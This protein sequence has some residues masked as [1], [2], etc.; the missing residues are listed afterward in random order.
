MGSLT[1]PPENWCWVTLVTKPSYL[2]G[3]IVLAHTLDQ[4]QSKYPL[5]VQYTDSLGDKA[6]AALQEEAEIYG[7]MKLERVSLLLPKKDQENTGS[8]AERFKDTFT[9]LRAFEVYNLGFT[10]AVFLD[11]DMAVFQNPDDIFECK[12]PGRDWIGANHACV[13]NLD[14]DPW[15]PSEWH[16]GNCAYTP[17]NHPD[18]VASAV[19]SE[20]RPTYHLLNS[21]MFLFYPSEQLWTRMLHFFNVSSQ[22]K[23]YQFPDQDFLAAFFRGK[24]HPLS[25]KYNALKTMRY[26]HPRIW[27]DDK[28]IVLHYIVDKP[29]ERQV[30]QDGVAG[31]LGRDGETHQWWW[32]LYREWRT[33]RKDMQ[34]K[35]MGKGMA[36]LTVDELVDTEEPFTKKIPLPQDV[37]RPEDVL[38]YP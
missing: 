3:V 1:D 38:P 13:C 8:V 4:H 6:L 2:P 30:S 15:A 36:V 17:L 11:A 34:Q 32:K 21:G 33:Q 9:K 14:N 27:S 20:S 18:D 7:R 16:K 22:L 19:S 29:W 10:R 35:G 31:H 24:W 37:G 26:W 5:L 12:L 28:L 23:N 25:W